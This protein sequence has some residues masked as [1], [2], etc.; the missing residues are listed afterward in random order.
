MNEAKAKMIKMIVI[1]VLIFW[2]SSFMYGV[3]ASVYEHQVEKNV[4]SVERVA[5][6]GNKHNS[7]YLI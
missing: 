6:Q 7:E 2:V 4:Y 5:E 3:A 1:G